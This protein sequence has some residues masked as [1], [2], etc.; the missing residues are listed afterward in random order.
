MSPLK[1][2]TNKDVP[3]IQ[4]VEYQKLRGLTPFLYSYKWHMFDIFPFYRLHKNWPLLCLSIHSISSKPTTQLIKWPTT[5]S[6]FKVHILVAFQIVCAPLSWQMFQ[7]I[8]DKYFL[9]L[10]KTYGESLPWQDSFLLQHQGKTLH[11]WQR[12]RTVFT[13]TVMSTDD[14]EPTKT[15]LC[16][17]NIKFSVKEINKIIHYQ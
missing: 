8:F 3:M 10:N 11:H 2:Q 1:S 4:L 14:F 15:Y 6:Q 7:R 13:S 9:V 16:P 12:A 17:R 5:I